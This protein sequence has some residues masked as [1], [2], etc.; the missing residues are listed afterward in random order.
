MSTALL[1]NVH[2]QAACWELFG[3]H[4]YMG[5][6]W[7]IGAAMGRHLTC[8]RSNCVVLGARNSWQAAPQ[9]ATANPDQQ[10]P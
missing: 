9:R 5:A 2:V 10:N 8:Q 1:R 7:R 4:G 6:G 3:V